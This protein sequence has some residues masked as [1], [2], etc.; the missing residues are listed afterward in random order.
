MRRSTKAFTLVKSIATSLCILGVITASLFVSNTAHSQTL[1]SNAM[2]SSEN[3]TDNHSP[4]SPVLED[5]INTPQD[6]WEFIADTVMGG[7][8]SGTV[9]FLEDNG[10]GLLKLTGTVSTA[11]NGGFIQARLPLDR[12]ATPTL[13]ESAQ[14]LW[15]KVRGNGQKYFVH[16]RTSGTV[17]PWQYYQAAFEAD[18]DWQVIELPWTNFKP[19]GGLSGSLLRDEPRAQ[20]I[21]SIA[22]VAFGRDHEADVEVAQI[23]YY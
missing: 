1:E 6:R 22:I 20:K 23:G 5:F 19:S 7:V 3:Q 12:T 4:A 9:Q 15:L 13:P 2:S 14:G 17:L 10:Q 8:S 21:K 11:N 18:N 16:V